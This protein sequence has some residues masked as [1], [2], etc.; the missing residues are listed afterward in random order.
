MPSALDALE[1]ALSH[2]YIDAFRTA[3]LSY[4]MLNTLLHFAEQFTFELGQL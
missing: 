3:V 1:P 2:N 4:L